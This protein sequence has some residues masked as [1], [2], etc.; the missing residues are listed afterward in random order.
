M[1]IGNL[2]YLLRNFSSNI[3]FQIPIFTGIKAQYIK[4]KTFVL[5]LILERHSKEN[6]YLKNIKLNKVKEYLMWNCN[7]QTF[8]NIYK[9]HKMRICYSGIL[10]H[11]MLIRRYNIYLILFSFIQR[12]F[13]NIN[14]CKLDTILSF[15]INLFKNKEFS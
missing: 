15:N 2:F 12:F 3:Y 1:R 4:Q 5:L 13:I 9:V 14:L 8:K 11:F 7:N 6:V 10:V